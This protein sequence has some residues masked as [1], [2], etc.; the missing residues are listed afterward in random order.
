MFGFFFNIK[1]MTSQD[2]LRFLLPLVFSLQVGSVLAN[3]EVPRQCIAD[4]EDLAQFLP[5]NDSGASAELADHGNAIAKAFQ[6]ARQEAAQAADNTACDKILRSYLRS[7]RPGHLGLAAVPAQGG[8]AGAAAV[9]DNKAQGDPR[10]PQ[11]RILG[12]DTLLFVF[13]SFEDR[14]KARVKAMLADHRAELESH[15]NWIIDVRANVGGSDSTYAPLL[16]WLLDGEFPQHKVEWLV[17]PAN[18]RA[19]E[20][21]C[22]TVSDPNACSAKFEPII[23]AM[24]AAAPGTFVLSS[25]KKFEFEHPPKGEPHPPARVAVL[26]DHGCGSSCEQFLLEA[27]TSFRVKLLGR[28]SYGALDYSNLRRHSLPSGRVLNYATSRTTRLPD[29]MIDQIGIAPDLLLPKP[30]DDAAREAEVLQVQRWLETGSFGP[31]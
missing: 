6:N 9:A 20:Q 31:L 8:A 23:K 10:A 28:P 11:F 17:T 4:L 15:K 18:I 16:L 26:V 3:T 24:R 7:W 21:L 13:G 2:L 14:Y 1:K 30:A 19:Q 5:V 29:M 27:R 25:G 12:K 22:A